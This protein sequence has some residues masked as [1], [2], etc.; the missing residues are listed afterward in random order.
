M[1]VPQI[2]PLQGMVPSAIP[3]VP[4]AKRQEQRALAKIAVFA[5]HRETG[6]PVWQ[7]GLAVRDSTS[8]DTWVLGAGPFQRGTIY[9]GPSFAGHKIKNPLTEHTDA[10]SEH[11]SVGIEAEA[12]FAP[13]HLFAEMPEPFVAPEEGSQPVSP[14]SHTS[15]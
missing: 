8:K 3:E 6:M 10:D 2:M 13:P 4:F 11:P 9:E 5:Y 15:P 7:S 1:Q 14:A 12:S